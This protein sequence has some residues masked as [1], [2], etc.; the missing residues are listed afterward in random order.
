MSERKGSKRGGRVGKGKGGGG[1][2]GRHGGF[3][4]KNAKANRHIFKIRTDADIA[5]DNAV[6]NE[7][8]AGEDE[9]DDGRHRIES[10]FIDDD[11]NVDV[12]S[13][14]GDDDREG[15]DLKRRAEFAR[16]LYMW[17]FGQN[18]PKRF[19]FQAT[20][21]SICLYACIHCRLFNARSNIETL[22]V[23]IQGQSCANW[24]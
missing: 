16:K 23:E 3:Y 19:Q 4:G 21:H 14:N 9:I 2:G 12:T 18:D 10:D 1:I 6:V 24:V 7:D 15:G 5:A 20:I 8:D 22:T 13:A 11:D 17:E